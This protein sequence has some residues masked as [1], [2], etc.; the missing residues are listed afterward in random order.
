MFAMPP[1]QNDALFTGLLSNSRV[2]AERT[3][4]NFVGLRRVLT[5]DSN[6][7]LGRYVQDQS[8]KVDFNAWSR[9]ILEAR[10]RVVPMYIAVIMISLLLFIPAATSREPWI[11]L[12]I[13][14]TFIPFMWP[15]L[16]NYYYIVLM[17]MA[18][19][20]S[21]SWNV[22]FPLLGIGIIMNM[23]LLLGMRDDELYVLFSASICLGAAAI[24]WQIGSPMT[25]W[26]Q[27]ISRFVEK[28]DSADRI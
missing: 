7:S 17:V 14:S 18:T 20:F 6:S 9:S 11:A 21:A 8:A 2:H 23:G 22:A 15:E 16:S 25:F 27:A 19:I 13:G 28:K 3:G 24:W 5:F 12:V 1:D 4:V 10:K 26:R